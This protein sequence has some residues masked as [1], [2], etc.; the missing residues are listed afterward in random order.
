MLVKTDILLK[1][2]SLHY[3]VDYIPKRALHYFSAPENREEAVP[4]LLEEAQDFIANPADYIEE[5]MGNRFLVHALLILGSLQEKQAMCLIRQIGLMPHELIDELLG[6]WLFDGISLA[7][8]EIFDGRVEELKELIEDRELDPSVRAACIQSLLF[9]Y[10]RGALSREEIISY[11]RRQLDTPE[12]GLPFFYEIIASAAIA[13]HPEELIEPLRRLYSEG[14]IDDSQVQL[15]EIEESLSL[16]KAA[17]L[18]AFR[19]TLS[20]RLEDPVQYLENLEAISQEVPY[21]RN[22]PCPCGS[23]QKFK[24][25]CQ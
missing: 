17:S 21:E 12:K 9:L 10:G 24:K 15:Q 7:I 14:I 6:D 16:P 8:A 4:L 18:E 5:T 1:I 20:M 13:L 2:D 25:C 22:E 3:A 19:E 23:G 11:L